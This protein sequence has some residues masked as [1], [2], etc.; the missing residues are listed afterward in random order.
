[1][2][3]KALMK[4]VGLIFV[5]ALRA[6][7]GILMSWCSCAYSLERGFYG[8]LRST[9]PI[10]NCL[11]QTVLAAVS[12]SPEM[13]SVCLISDS[14]RTSM[15]KTT[16][17]GVWIFPQFA[18]QLQYYITCILYIYIYHPGIVQQVRPW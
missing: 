9:L 2:S 3:D 16:S 15:L 10:L 5:V 14:L 6:L 7:R 12:G 4:I 8:P 17:C 1:M 13:A 18:K 11:G